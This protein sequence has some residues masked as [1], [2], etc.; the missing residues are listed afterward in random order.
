MSTLSP[1]LEDKWK[2]VKEYY[3]YAYRVELKDGL[4]PEKIE[5]LYS[6]MMK[7]G[8]ELSREFDRGR[9]DLIRYLNSPKSLRSPR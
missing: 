4:S 6:Q 2:A 3:S 8:E 9:S 5:W 1:L 7:L